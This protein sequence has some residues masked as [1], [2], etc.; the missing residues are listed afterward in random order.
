LQLGE[1]GEGAV[2][3]AFGSGDGA[4]QEVESGEF[5]DGHAQGFGFEQAEAAQAPGVLDELDL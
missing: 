3:G 2:A 5:G 1:G 4:L